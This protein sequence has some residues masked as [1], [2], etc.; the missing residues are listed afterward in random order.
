MTKEQMLAIMEARFGPIRGYD[1]GS[2]KNWVVAYGYTVENYHVR[3]SRDYEDAVP[4]DVSI[5]GEATVHGE[6]ATLNDALVKVREHQ[7]R[8]LG[9]LHKTPIP[10]QK[11]HEN[12]AL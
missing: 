8:L 12:E 11:P 5:V 7:H 10:I 4:W 2:G 6:G 9:E 1:F 3:L